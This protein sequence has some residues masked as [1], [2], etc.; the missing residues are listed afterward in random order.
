MPF[1]PFHIGPVFLLGMLFTGTLYMPALLAGCVVLDF[2]PLSVILFN[3]PYLRHG[4]AHNFLIGTIVAIVLALII[5]AMRGWIGDVAAFFMLEQEA[6]F[7]KI[8][9][10]CLIG[11]Y[12]HILLDGL[13][14]YIDMFPFWPSP[15]NPLPTMDKW[16]LMAICC[17]AFALGFL[18]YVG[19]LLANISETTR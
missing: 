10:S 13:L 9:L 12:S 4:H 6:T 19:R 14:H 8:M 11:V 15:V 7:G 18:L 1:T 17:A 16:V 3:L 2:E 5:Y